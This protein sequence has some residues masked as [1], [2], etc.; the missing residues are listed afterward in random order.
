MSSERIMVIGSGTRFVSGISHYT[1]EL[2]CAF[3]RG[4]RTSVVLMRR[5]LPRR[6]YPGAK[7]VG[8]TIA[9]HVYP[10]DVRVYD[11]VDWFWF[12]SLLRALRLLWKERPEVVVLQWW[13]G[14]VAHTYIALVAF[15]RLRGARTIL[16]MHE[17]QDTGEARIP[18]ASS[19]TRTMLRLLILLA[20][21]FVIH[22]DADREVLTSAHRI[23][24]KPLQVIRHGPYAHYST[25]ADGAL[26]DA[27]PD[28]VNLMYFGTIRP[29][30]GLEDLVLAFDSI[31]DP[32][33]FWL[34]VVGETWEGWTLPAEL[35]AASPCT[36]RITFVNRYVTEQE[37]ASLLAGADA[38]VL[39]YH[40]SSASGPLHIGMALGLP[41]V[42]T[43]IPALV[44]A[45]AGYEGCVFV[46]PRSP[47]RLREALEAIPALVGRRYEDPNSWDE[48]VRCYQELIG[49]LKVQS[50]TNAARRHGPIR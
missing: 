2:A 48:T 23:V 30:K 42:I 45:T 27:P 34:T 31:A 29:Y 33:R 37:A 9:N 10:R 44:E 1:H 3:S 36:D 4:H 21:G 18:F 17:I 49:K 11:G 22:S 15:A 38:L 13:T 19:Y 25:P 50:R 24:D 5:L 28:A 20:N 6:F 16:E 43:D 39:P 46:P 12:P 40:R 47:D 7:R 26:R 32:S 14:T 35:I 41:V 8:A